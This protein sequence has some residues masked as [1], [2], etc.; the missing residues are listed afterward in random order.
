MRKIYL[1]TKRRKSRYALSLSWTADVEHGAP[2]RIM[3][4]YRVA[5]N[6][7]VFNDFRTIFFCPDFISSR[8]YKQMNIRLI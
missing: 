3:I 1:F 8:M 4:G 6:T 2:R 7:G 5:S